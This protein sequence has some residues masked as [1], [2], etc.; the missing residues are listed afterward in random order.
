MYIGRKEG[1]NLEFEHYVRFKLPS[2]LHLSSY[3][4]SMCVALASDVSDSTCLLDD[5]RTVLTGLWYQDKAARIPAYTG[6]KWLDYL[7]SQGLRG[8]LF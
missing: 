2:S 6:M 3:T 7:L 4:L 8:W 5:R 1:L